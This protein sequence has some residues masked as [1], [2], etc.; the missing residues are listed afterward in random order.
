MAT[1]CFSEGPILDLS[2][3]AYPTL[4]SSSS[5]VCGMQEA[6]RLSGTQGYLGETR[7]LWT[8]CTPCQTPNSALKSYLPGVQY[9]KIRLWIMTLPKEGSP[10][11]FPVSYTM[12][13]EVGTNQNLPVICFCPYQLRELREINTLLK[14]SH[15]QHLGTIAC[16][17]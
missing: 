3:A 11:S 10:E 9:L 5:P 12:C 6:G 4:S 2:E 8:A 13:E 7:M 17:G 15:L 14:P 16:G 1:T